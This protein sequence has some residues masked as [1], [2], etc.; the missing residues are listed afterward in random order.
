MR[1]YMRYRGSTYCKLDVNNKIVSEIATA[2]TTKTID[3]DTD[4]KAI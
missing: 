3:M 2:T 4:I 1:N